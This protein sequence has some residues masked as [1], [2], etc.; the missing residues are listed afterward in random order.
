MMHAEIHQFQ[1][2]PGKLVSVTRIG[3]RPANSH[4][5]LQDAKAQLSEV[6]RRAR[7]DGPQRVTVH[8]RDGVI[9]VAEEEFLRLQ[10]D[11]TGA[12]LVD[13]MQASPLKGVR[14]EARRDRMP[15]R[16]LRAL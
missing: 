7:Q 13:A 8:G 16:R 1:Q 6:V 9:V 3:R 4:W 10:G 2:D 12:G 5:M 14:L 15:V 11:V